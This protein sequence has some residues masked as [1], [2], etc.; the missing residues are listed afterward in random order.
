MTGKPVPVANP[1]SAV[2]WEACNEKRFLIQSC[3]SCGEKQFYPRALCK[4]CHSKDLEWQE[5]SGRGK[6]KTFT[7]VNHAPS[8]AFK[9]DLPYV[10][11]LI[12]LEEG[13]RAMMNILD[14]DVA[15]V[16]IGM[17]VELTFERRGKQYIPQAK[18]VS[19]G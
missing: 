9:A 12:D 13:V 10:L 7:V 14:C 3:N 6:V 8:P 5:V 15:D 17:D 2:F 11:A 4:S 16:H 19:K 18:P 1:D